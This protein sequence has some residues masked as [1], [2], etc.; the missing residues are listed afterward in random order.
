MHDFAK[1]PGLS[2]AVAVLATLPSEAFSL[3]HN[4]MIS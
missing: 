4:G 3:P 1:R 2:R